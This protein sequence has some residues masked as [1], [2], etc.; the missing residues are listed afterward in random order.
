MK[1]GIYQLNTLKRMKKTIL[2]FVSALLLSCLHVP[3]FASL[4]DDTDGSPEN[5][6]AA[7]ER[8]EGSVTERDGSD[9]VNT[10]PSAAP[11]PAGPVV[12]VL[13]VE[14]SPASEVTRI[15]VPVID[16]QPMLLDKL[17]QSMS[18]TE[19]SGTAAEK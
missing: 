6:A 2:L 11:V 1:N 13:V 8:T 19:E 3:C 18:E 16:E 17:L 5:A 7:P 10:A 4:P 14:P 9:A 15:E 12:P